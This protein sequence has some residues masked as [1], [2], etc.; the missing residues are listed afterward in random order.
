MFNQLI[1]IAAAQG[2]WTLLSIVLIIY[3]IQVQKLRDANQ[4]KREENYIN[5]IK[6]LVEKE[7]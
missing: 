7:K 5:L 2:I 3:I 6:E 4:Q 1:K